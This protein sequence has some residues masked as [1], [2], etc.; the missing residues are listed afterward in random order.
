[1]IKLGFVHRFDK[2]VGATDTL[3]SEPDGFSLIRLE[4]MM[5]I[6]VSLNE[7]IT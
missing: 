4:E 6:V 5:I 2:N 7:K 3:F 1:M